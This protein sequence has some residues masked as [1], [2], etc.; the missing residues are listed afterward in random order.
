MELRVIGA[1]LGRTGTYS[2]KLALEMA[3]F[4]PCYH[5]REVGANPAHVP[6]WQTRSP[7]GGY[8]G[9]VCERLD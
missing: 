5:M 6:V 8:G 9:G 4:G 7:R 1:G 2:L 3:G